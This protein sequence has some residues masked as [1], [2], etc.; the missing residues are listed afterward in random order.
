VTIYDLISFPE[1]V[2]RPSAYIGMSWLELFLKS[3]GATSH[4]VA[5]TDDIQMGS[6]EFVPS[7]IRPTVLRNLCRSSSSIDWLS[8]RSIL[9]TRSLDLPIRVSDA[10]PA[11]ANSLK[12]CESASSI[13]LPRT[14]VHFLLQHLMVLHAFLQSR[15]ALSHSCQTCFQDSYIRINRTQFNPQCIRR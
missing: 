5:P 2:P 13:F 7:Q 3:A 12:S 9:A 4:I 11:R 10:L 1:S 15:R 14:I 6:P 8:P